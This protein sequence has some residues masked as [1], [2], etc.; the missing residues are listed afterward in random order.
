MTTHDE[1]KKKLSP[2]RQAR[3]KARAQ[4][5]IAEELT[6]RELRQDLQ[7]SQETVAEL[8]GMRQGDLS[9]F[10]RRHDA[11][12]ST[13]RRYVEA[14][15]GTLDLVAHFPNRVPVHL[16][17]IGD[18]YDDVGVVKLRST[19]NMTATSKRTKRATASGTRSNRK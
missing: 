15:G 2:E 4:E 13:I 18:L 19:A 7:M 1:Y 9:K 12:L 14:M 6:L 10:E 17:N 11:Y 16:V 8:L 3:I 5:L